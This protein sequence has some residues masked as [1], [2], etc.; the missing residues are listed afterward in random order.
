MTRNCL[1]TLIPDEDPLL[2]HSVT[3][4]DIDSTESKEVALDTVPMT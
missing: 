3:T 1:T 4:T 2:V